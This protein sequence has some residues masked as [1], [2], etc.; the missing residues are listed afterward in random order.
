MDKRRNEQ[1]QK[2]LGGFP[3]GGTH[4]YLHVN[5]H[6]YAPTWNANILMESVYDYNLKGII[7]LNPNPVPIPAAAW[8]LGTGI[9]GLIAL[10]RKIR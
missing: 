2:P 8:M 5:P 7:E 6:P 1:L 4:A 9:M 10:R 3:E